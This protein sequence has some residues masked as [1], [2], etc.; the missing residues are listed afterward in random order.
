RVHSASY[1]FPLHDALPIWTCGVKSTG[2]S[3]TS[4]PAGAAEAEPLPTAPSPR[5]ASATAA[6]KAHNLLHRTLVLLNLC[7]TS[8]AP[9]SHGRSEEHTSELQSRENL[10]CR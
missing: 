1:A 4:D 9:P 10:V 2:S 5:A 7:T 3:L 6:L 8:P